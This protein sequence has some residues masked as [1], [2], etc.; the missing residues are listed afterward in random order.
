MQ[1]DDANSPIRD[2]V[3]SRQFDAFLQRLDPNRDQAGEKY[4]DLRRRLIKFF[5]WNSCFPAEDLVDETLDRVVERLETVQVL[6]VVAF[7][8]GFAKHIRQEAYKRSERIVQ[9]ADLPKGVQLPAEGKNQE[10]ALQEAR[11]DEWRTRCLR[12]CLRRFVP[13]D[14]E[15]FLKYHN[16]KGDHT[17]YRSRLAND[18]GISIGTLRVRINRLRE[19]LET[20]LRECMAARGRTRG[21]EKP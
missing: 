6:D 9:I 4:E 19:K 21:F 18:L 5:E 11:E 20:C 17:A 10:R 1:R 7:A 14:R 2:K 12:L 15:V 13:A 3:Q 16:V 8:W